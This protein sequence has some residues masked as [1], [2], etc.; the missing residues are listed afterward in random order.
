M[1]LDKEG[2]MKL[3]WFEKIIL[4]ER[5]GDVFL[6]VL[7]F[8]TAYFYLVN[9]LIFKLFF[10]A[11]SILFNKLISLIILPMLV[12]AAIGTGFVKL[13]EIKMNYKRR[14]QWLNRRN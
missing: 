10:G 6:F 13:M 5:F 14:K 9:N 2:N 11:E 12:G 7:G 4:D 8:S 1:K 3:N